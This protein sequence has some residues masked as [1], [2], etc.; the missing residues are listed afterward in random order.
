MFG[1]FCFFLWVKRIVEKNVGLYMTQIYRV[2]RLFMKTVQESLEEYVEQGLIRHEQLALIREYENRKDAEELQR[3]LRLPE[4]VKIGFFD[5]Q[6][7]D[8][9]FEIEGE[10][11]E[12]S[13]IDPTHVYF[14]YLKC[15]CY[16]GELE[17]W[18]INSIYE[19][20]NDLMDYFT[21]REGGFA[22]EKH[23][24][25]IAYI[26]W[27]SPISDAQ[28]NAC[29]PRKISAEHYSL[30]LLEGLLESLDGKICSPDISGSFGRDRVL[31]ELITEFV[32]KIAQELISS[33]SMVRHRFDIYEEQDDYG[34]KVDM[35]SFSTSWSELYTFEKYGIQDEMLCGS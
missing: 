7:Y 12:Y 33:H 4:V 27:L 19:Y 11:S 13:A 16:G 1:G 8:A 32:R 23:P 35:F 14:L 18:T 25:L 24:S 9:S 34:S 26:D 22:A 3:L 29:D 28:I 5:E 31:G 30:E 10:W 17:E 20:H 15:K 21:D 6:D 2:E